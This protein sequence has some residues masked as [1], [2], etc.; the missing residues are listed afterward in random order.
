MPVTRTATRALR[1]SKRKEQRNKV[2]RARIK[3]VVKLS[4]KAQAGKEKID[5]KEFVQKAYKIVDKAAKRNIIHKN[6]A[7]RLKSRILKRLASKEEKV[8]KKK[9]TVKKARK[10]TTKKKAN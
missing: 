6:K 4:K 2:I 8:E 9:K 7:A 10:K 1:K 5:E 3:D